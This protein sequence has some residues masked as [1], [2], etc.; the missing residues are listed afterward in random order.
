VGRVTDGEFKEAYE[1]TSPGTMPLTGKAAKFFGLL[2][3]FVQKQEEGSIGLGFNAEGWHVSVV[4]GREA[5]DSPMAGG[6]AHGSGTLEEALRSAA[7]E[8]GLVK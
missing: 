2:S 1:P 5:E 4:F 6:A 3:D 8:C 7:E